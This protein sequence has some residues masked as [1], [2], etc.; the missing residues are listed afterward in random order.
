MAR[1]SAIS[2]IASGTLKAELKELYGYVIGNVQKQTL[3][4]SLKSQEYTGNPAAGSVEFRRFANSKSKAYGTARST[5]KG[6]AI[7]APPIPVNLSV[8]K[9]IVEEAAKFDIDTFGIGNL[10]VRRVDNHSLTMSSELDGAFFEAAFADGTDFTPA[11][12]AFEDILEENIQALE[13][14]NNDFVRGVPRSIMN[15]VCSTSFF[16][17]IRNYLDTKPNPNVDTAA[18]GFGVFHG[19]K[20]YSH[21]NVPLTR[22]ATLMI[23]GA[24]AQPVVSYQYTE[25]EKIPLS[26]D[27]GVGLF[28]DYG[29]KV[30]TPDLVF[31]Y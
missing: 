8:H 20:V 31:N 19:V 11:E 28:Y 10:M 16:G 25:P 15:M 14:V 30:L 17:K 21:I 6:D 23:D 24:I 27:Y 9:E 7:Q 2:L 1:T 18:E 12:T 5:G 22:K 3:A 4:N 13:T 29:T 26:N